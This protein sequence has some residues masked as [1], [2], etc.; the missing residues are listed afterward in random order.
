MNV[1]LVLSLTNL[2]ALRKL[3]S[4]TDILKSTSSIHSSLFRIKGMQ[5]AKLDTPRGWRGGGPFV[6]TRFVWL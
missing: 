4:E 2:C 6:F 5:D 1:L 3:S